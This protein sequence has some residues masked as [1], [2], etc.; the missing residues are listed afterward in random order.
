MGGSGG[1]ATTWRR[2][3]L[4]PPRMEVRAGTV[5][6]RAHVQRVSAEGGGAAAAVATAGRSELGQGGGALRLARTSRSK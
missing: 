4:G 1:V 6:R 3:W 5:I 2:G